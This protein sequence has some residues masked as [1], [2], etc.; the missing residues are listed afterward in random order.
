MRADGEYVVR[1]QMAAFAAA[2]SHVTVGSSN[3]N[4]RVDLE[5][6]LLSRSG[7]GQGNMQ[8]RTAAR[9]M[10]NRGFQSLSVLQSEV[11]ADQGANGGDSVAPSGMPVP[12]VPPTIATES[13]AVSG[14]NSPSLAGMS[15][16]EMRSRY[17]QDGQ[18]GGI[19]SAAG[20]PLGG[21]FGGPGGRGGGGGPI[22]I[23]GRG[24]NMKPA[25][26]TGY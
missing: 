19:S 23:G 1:A 26:G 16:D 21:G 15:A 11:G 25:R 5:I 6:V 2:V 20:G 10:G 24:S 18:P 22:R 7:S 4:P 8:G 17:Q 9:A 12:G 3:Q 13:V 14:S